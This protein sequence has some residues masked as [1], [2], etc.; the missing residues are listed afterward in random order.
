MIKTIKA[1]WTYRD[2]L[3]TLVERDL[4]VKYRRSILGYLWSLLNPLLMMLVISM[5]FSY[6]FRFQIENYPI[7][8]LTGQLIFG[9]F[10]EATNNSMNSI[11]IG[12]ALIKKV[13]IP[14]YMFPLAR[15]TSS[16][17]NMLFSMIALLIMLVVTKTHF[18]WALLFVPIALSYVFLF[19]L[20]IG[21]ILSVLA[22][23]FRD[24]VHLYG[25]L[26]TALA[27]FTPIFY[28]VDILPDALKGFMQFNPLYHYVTCFREIVLNG[29]MPSLYTNLMCIGFA[30]LFAGLGCMIFKRHQHNFIL[31]I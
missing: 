10:S 30:V 27:Y 25:V 11:L 9:F 22:V 16:F 1:F 26:L 8:L 19:A 12:G 13:Y 23:Y 18:T 4:K 2:L 31:H 17:I 15:T 3:V 6:L 14:K 21:F 28:P 5:V 20:G 29:R 24:M 7:Y